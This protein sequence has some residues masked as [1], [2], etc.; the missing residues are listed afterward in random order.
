MKDSNPTQQQQLQFSELVQV[1]EGQPVTTSLMVAEYFA[2][3]HK[4]VLRAINL[5]D[6][7]ELFRER[8]FAP[9]SYETQMPNGGTRKT[10]MYYI[11]RDGFTFLVMG[12]TGRVAAKFKEDYINAFNA[13]EETLR[14]NEANTVVELER[15]FA[16]ISD[17]LMSY[18]SKFEKKMQDEQRE[19]N[20]VN[21]LFNKA[22]NPNH[23]PK[24]YF[25][26]I[27]DCFSSFL[28]EE[29][30]KGQWRG[31]TSER[32]VSRIEAARTLYLE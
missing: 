26:A 9:T 28:K 31:G 4:D 20:P 2:K 8:N 25:L 14:K 5:L 7:S 30:D 16:L 3:H 10:T 19:K 24:E 12:F 13:M 1:R 17:R 6:C 27:L 32:L 18:M 21:E 22:Y 23:Y 11:T 29:F 15:Q